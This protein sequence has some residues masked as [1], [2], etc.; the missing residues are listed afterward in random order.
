M[1][2]LFRYL[3]VLIALQYLLLSLYVDGVGHY[4]CPDCEGV[5][6][7]VFKKSSA[8]KNSYFRD[9]SGKERFHDLCPVAYNRSWRVEKRAVEFRGAFQDSL[10]AFFPD[11]GK[12]FCDILAF[13]P[14][15]S[16]PI[17]G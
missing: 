2:D 16:P 11:G 3:N 13:A 10:M 12:K 17:E 5:I 14:K 15:N 1:K 9:D 7:L 6:H 4:R 8:E